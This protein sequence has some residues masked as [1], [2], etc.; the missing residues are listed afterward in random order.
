MFP[1]TV[2]LGEICALV[3]DKDAFNLNLLHQRVRKEGGDCD[4]T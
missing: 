3:Q 2:K 1:T 4:L